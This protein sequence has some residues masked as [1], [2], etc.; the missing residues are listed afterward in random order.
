MRSVAAGLIA[1]S[2]LATGSAAF[3]QDAGLLWDGTF[4][5]AMTS[6]SGVQAKEGGITVVAAPDGRAGVA[7]RFVVRPGDDPIGATG[8]RA[9]VFKRT[10]EHAGISS[11]WGWSVFFP[12]GYPSSPNTMWN[13]FTDWHHNGSHG[14]QPFSFEITNERGREWLRLRVWGGNIDNPVQRA[15]QLAPLV[16]GRWYDFALRV[17]WAP[18]ANGRVQVWLD[19]REVVPYTRTPTLYAGQGVYM[20]QGFYRA[21]SKVTSEVYIARTRRVASIADLGIGVGN[22]AAQPPPMPT[23]AAAPGG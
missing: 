18:D 9:E 16:R 14:V 5:D 1:F 20:K 6:W 7:A 12:R 11:I 3:A 4:D 22:K 19:H 10:G 17:T 23:S 13:V 8:E 15:W 2:L 21:P